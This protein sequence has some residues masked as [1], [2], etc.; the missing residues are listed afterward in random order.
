MTH[1]L[2][3]G[4]S[5]TDSKLPELRRSRQDVI[6]ISE[7]FR[8]LVDDI[9]SRELIDPTRRDFAEGVKWLAGH[10][11]GTL[12]FYFS[13]HAIRKRT[14]LTSLMCTDS[15]LSD[16]GSQFSSRDLG[17]MLGSAVDRSLLIIL[18]CC[19]SADV[20][21]E[22]R[23]SI[24]YQTRGVMFLLSSQPGLLTL[25]PAQDTKQ[26][27][28]SLSR[29]TSTFTR[30][31]ALGLSGVAQLGPE[32]DFR[33]LGE[34]A[35]VEALRLGVQP[36]TLIQHGI[37]SDL[38]LPT[39]LAPNMELV[40]P[41]EFHG[42]AHIR[43]ISPTRTLGVRGSL[44]VLAASTAQMA[45]D[46]GNSASMIGAGHA[47]ASLTLSEWRPGRQTLVLGLSDASLLDTIPLNRS[48]RTVA[49]LG[50]S[51]HGDLLQRCDVV[52]DVPIVSGSDIERLLRQ[53]PSDASTLTGSIEAVEVLQD[54]SGDSL[55]LAALLCGRVAEA[56][57]SGFTRTDVGD[58][59][60]ELL[61]R[62]NREKTTA[63]LLAILSSA[64][65]VPIREHMLAA[66][67]VDE[68]GVERSEFNRSVSSLRDKRVVATGVRGLWITPR[69][70]EYLASTLAEL[71]PAGFDRWMT[72]ATGSIRGPSRKYALAVLSAALETP[73]TRSDA[74][75]QALKSVGSELTYWAGPEPT[76]RLFRL[77]ISQRGYEN[78]AKL[79][80]GLG[81][82]LRLSDAY[83]PAEFAFR[84]A[85]R[86]AASRLERESASVGLASAQK[87]MGSA[88]ARVD[89]GGARFLVD[90][91]VRARGLFQ[92]GN[93]LFAQSKWDVAHECY[94]EAESLLS[95]DRS[96][97]SSLLVDVWKGLGDIALHRGQSGVADSLSTDCLDLAH[98]HGM[99]AVDPRAVAKV[100]QFLGDAQ[101]HRMV[102]E[103]PMSAAA[104]E[105]SHWWYSRSRDVYG[106]RGLELGV[107]ISSFRMGQLL[108]ARGRHNAA[109][110]A[111]EDLHTSF[112]D[113][114]Q[115]LWVYKCNVLMA[116][117][118]QVGGLRGVDVSSSRDAVRAGLDSGGLSPYQTAWGSLALGDVR[119]A[120]RLLLEVGAEPLAS[121]LGARGFGDWLGGEY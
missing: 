118:A 93:I 12:V 29:I 59:V 46:A 2:A 50:P 37:C 67:F 1:L 99:M 63:S 110:G 107:H 13:G 4:V 10:G 95:A 57:T 61:S 89:P 60:R 73:I 11:C 30:S 20:A 114:K 86:F 91:L 62:L 68:L 106:S 84:Q 32:T 51:P 40:K 101:R 33:R 55:E 28:L 108:F 75:I 52:V 78:D 88:S 90:Q 44:G 48:A 117:L 41:R 82:A 21:E 26:S 103:G 115:A 66:Y 76:E 17:E 97:H 119:S 98:R 31:I 14:H 9:D 39:V 83:S 35:H 71:I 112:A 121:R 18:D 77:L 85:Y 43:Q 45:L 25:E 116:I 65:A 19:F 92:R 94:S 42:R 64:P 96:G 120:T 53:A 3:V 27:A 6:T 8:T 70:R 34:L 56:P 16:P 7:S 105:A 87:N 104:Y 113:L 36:P 49:T 47:S 74:S 80:L 5:K 15:S 109:L 69:V 54:L 102:D 38:V 58:L 79:W 111:M 100:A 23:G 22:I 81:D 24:G 72:W